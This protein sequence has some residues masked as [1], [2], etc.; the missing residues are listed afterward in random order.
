[1]TRLAVAAYPAERLPGLEA[2]EA[3]LDAWL[4]DAAEHGADL[5]VFPE[6]A[7]IE[8]ALAAA[9]AEP[10]ADDAAQTKADFARSAAQAGAYRDLVVHLAHRHRVH[11]VAGSL[12]VQEGAS[13][14]NRAYIV[15]PDGLLGWQDKCILTPW[16]RQ[17]TPLYAGT[18]LHRFET[19]F[20]ILGVLICYDCEF[21]LLA[22][23]LDA[24]ILAVPACTDSLAGQVRVRL[25]ARARALEGQ[26]I[27]CH[28]PLL[29]GDPACPLIDVNEG[30]AGV[31]APPDLGFPDDGILGDGAP[32]GAGWVVAQVDPATLQH[33]R[34]QGAVAPRR[35]WPESARCA[36]GDA[37]RTLDPNA[38]LK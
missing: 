21:P 25:S 37:I 38:P 6:Y 8:A 1:M 35:H 28:A 15:G 19:P 26:C 2:L 11:V 22:R 5:A 29:G 31:F 9:P 34:S 3:K 13:Y 7:G 27:T 24:D 32:N 14:V 17:N 18:R 16:E 33:S 36:L 23:Q 10:L 20:G 30:Q 4:S 12:P